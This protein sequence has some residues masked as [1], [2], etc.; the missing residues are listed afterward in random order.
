MPGVNGRI[1]RMERRALTADILFAGAGVAA[2]TSVILYL[3]SGGT[4][5]ERME[6]SAAPTEGGALFSFGGAF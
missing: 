6:L 4:T 2:A 1:D 5:E 3:T